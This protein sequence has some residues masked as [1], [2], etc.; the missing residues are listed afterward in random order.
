MREDG[1]S[2]AMVAAVVRPG[3]AAARCDQ[4]TVQTPGVE[5]G[6]VPSVAVEDTS[7]MG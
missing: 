3:N 1:G 6:I 4:R 5:G 2:T 7:E